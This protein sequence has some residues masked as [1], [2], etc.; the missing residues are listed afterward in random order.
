MRA[1][2]IDDQGGGISSTMLFW[3]NLR[4]ELIIMAAGL[5]SFGVL[6]LLAYAGNFALIGGAL[7]ATK[8]IGISPLL[9]FVAGILPHGMV[10]LPS[11]ILI[12]AAML[13]M[14]VRLVTPLEGRTIGE[15]MIIT[16]ADVMKV[17]IGV[18]IPLLLVAALVEANI[19]PRLLV[20]VL[21]HSLDIQP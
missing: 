17:F 7:A 2:L 9:V 14:G 8:L 13:Y 18:C 19:T 16:F 15:T 12:S 20:A 10:E 11:V 6:G 5:F 1:L 3:H 4:A 21:G